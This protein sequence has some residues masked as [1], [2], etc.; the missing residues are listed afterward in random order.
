M[1]SCLS[2]LRD[3]ICTPYFDDVIVYS[4][5]FEEHIDNVR[6]VLRRLGEHG[7]KLKPSKCHMFQK[8]V[9]CLG[10]VV[11]EDGH[12]KDPNNIDALIALK[13]TR[14]KTVGDVRKIIGL[15]GYYRGYVQDFSRIV[16]PIYDLLQSKDTTDTSNHHKLKTN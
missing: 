1:E 14:P 16:K 3:K 15:L 5:T 11:S 10:R 13:S 6:T 9:R 2:E 4:K 7:V 8:E 12:K